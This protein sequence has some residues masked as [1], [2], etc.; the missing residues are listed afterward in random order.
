MNIPHFFPTGREV[1]SVR[2]VYEKERKENM[3]MFHAARRVAFNLLMLLFKFCKQ[4][5]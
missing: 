4:E 2:T 1:W 3:L 5:I